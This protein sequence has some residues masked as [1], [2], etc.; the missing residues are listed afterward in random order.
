MVLAFLQH[1]SPQP[2]MTRFVASFLQSP[3][4]N[5]RINA[6]AVVLFIVSQGG[7]KCLIAT[8]LLCLCS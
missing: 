2:L 1:K 4:S 8:W 5:T 3:K 6:K 7:N